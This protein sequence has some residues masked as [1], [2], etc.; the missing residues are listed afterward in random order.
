MAR[1]PMNPMNKGR[2]SHP[3]P[4]VAFTDILLDGARVA[5]RHNHDTAAWPVPV[6]GALDFFRRKLARLRAG[7]LEVGHGFDD[8]P[9]LRFTLGIPDS[10]I[11]IDTQEF[12]NRLRAPG[13]FFCVWKPGASLP[14][15]INLVLPKDA[16][17]DPH[18]VDRFALATLLGFAFVG[19]HLTSHE[20]GTDER[21]EAVHEDVFSSLPCVVSAMFLTSEDD[22]ALVP[23]A[24]SAVSQFTAAMLLEG[25]S[26]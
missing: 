23:V 16:D 4:Q 6:R 5:S 24:A 17:P 22:E 13:R 20:P 21:I 10:I 3:G 12:A 2:G 26:A 11:N 7:E 15:Y 25:E 14:L 1:P 18:G 9:D 19:S 8:M